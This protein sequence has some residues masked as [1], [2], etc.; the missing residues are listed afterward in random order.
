MTAYTA[1]EMQRVGGSP[2]R[3]YERESRNLSDRDENVLPAP[4]TRM[5]SNLEE[6]TGLFL[7]PGGAF[8]SPWAIEAMAREGDEEAAREALRDLARSPMHDPLGGGIY[9]RRADLGVASTIETTS[10]LIVDASFTEVAARLSRGD[11]N[12]LTFARS[13]SNRVYYRLLQPQGA[14]RAIVSDQT[15]DGNSPYASLTF[16]RLDE[17]GLGGHAEEIRTALRVGKNP[18]ALGSLEGEASLVLRRYLDRLA[19]TR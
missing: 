9:L 1:S 16:R 17:A 3:L 11:P 6:G 15:P 18:Q 19:A 12:L 4:F 2:D 14:P 5:V 7:A 8:A 10:A 13:L